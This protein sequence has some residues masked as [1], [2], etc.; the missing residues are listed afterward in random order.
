MGRKK[1][2]EVTMKQYIGGFILLLIGYIF[3]KC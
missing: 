1:N 2:P 3:T